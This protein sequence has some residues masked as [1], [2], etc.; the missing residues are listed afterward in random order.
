SET[1]KY[2]KLL[3]GRGERGSHCYVGKLDDRSRSARGKSRLV[4]PGFLI[5]AAPAALALLPR[6]ISVTGAVL[7][8]DVAIVGDGLD[9]PFASLGPRDFECSGCASLGKMVVRGEH[10]EI[11]AGEVLQF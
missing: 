5:S 9:E 7:D 6:G 3:A 1:P 4:L 8:H 11:E 10:S 2:P